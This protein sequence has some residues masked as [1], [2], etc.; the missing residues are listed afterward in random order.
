M[1][2]GKILNREKEKS[3][4]NIESKRSSSEL[5]LFKLPK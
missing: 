3:I 1:N 5:K 4:K 2:F